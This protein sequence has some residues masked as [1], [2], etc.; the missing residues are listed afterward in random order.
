MAK[1]GRDVDLDE[2]RRIVE[3]LS[4]MLRDYDLSELS[5]EGEE[6]KVSVK[7]TPDISDLLQSAL[8]QPRGEAPAVERHPTVTAEEVPAEEGYEFITAPMPGTFYRSPTPGAEPFVEVGD[9]VRGKS[10]DYEGDTLCIIEAMKV[11]NEIKSDF[12]CQ[13]VEILAEN[14]QRVEYGQKLFKVKRR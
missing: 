3:A 11:M 6:F 7:R 5:Y 4:Q 12:D 1:K 10:E 9:E 13:I 2:L 14:G 8:L